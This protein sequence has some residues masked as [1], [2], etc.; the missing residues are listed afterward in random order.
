[1]DKTRLFLLCMLIGTGVATAQ[2]PD[3][4]LMNDKEYARYNIDT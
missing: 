1:M 4:S 2:Y 3:P